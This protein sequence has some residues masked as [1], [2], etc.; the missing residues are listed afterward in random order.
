L[1]AKDPARSASGVFV[2]IASRQ[3]HFVLSTPYPMFCS[4]CSNHPTL[5]RAMRLANKC[6]RDFIVDPNEKFKVLINVR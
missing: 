6:S 2:V 1:M 3:Y 4:Q 5:L